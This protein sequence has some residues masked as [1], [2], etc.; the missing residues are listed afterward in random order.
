MVK[1][2]VTFLMFKNLWSHL[3]KKRQ[4]QFFL[5]LVLMLISSISEVISMGAILPFLGV[6]TS[7]EQIYNHHL[8]QPIIQMLEIKGPEQLLLPVT[9]IFI[10]AAL[11]AGVVRIVLLYVMT[12]FSYAAGADI[13]IDIYRRTL[14][15]KYSDHIER[16][17]SEVINSIIV[18]TNTV[19]GN[20]LNPAL[21]MISSTVLLIGILYVL[22]IV[23]FKMTI[24]AISV[25]LT[26][27][28]GISFYTRKKLSRNSQCISDQSTK[29]IRSLQE[30]LGGIRDV[31]INGSQPFYCKLYRDADLALRSATGDN[32]FISQSP[33]YLME[34]L[35]MILIALLAYSMTQDNSKEVIPI[36]G[37][38]ALG[39]QKLLPVL[40][41]FYSSYSSI[42]GASSSFKD[43]LNLL[44]QPLPGYA[45]TNKLPEPLLHFKKEIKLSDISFR[46]A[47]DSPWVV[48]DVNLTIKK[49]E[50]VGFVG[51]TGDGKS[52]LVDIIMGLLFPEKG[53][54]KVDGKIINHQNIRSWHTCIAH[55]PQN[56]F[57]SD[58]TIEENI[59]FG[60]MKEE[61]DQSLLKKVA[62]QAKV[63]DF[64][65]K[66]HNGYQTI[67]GEQGVKLSGGQRQR[68]GIA[69]ALYN[70]SKVLVLDEATSALDSKTECEVMESIEEIDAEVT[71]LIIAHRITTLKACDKVVRLN[72]GKVVSVE[73]YQEL[74]NNKGKPKV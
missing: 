9:L 73:S 11:F 8:L 18:K 48:K 31:I 54:V 2:K 39:A 55:V 49:G 42:N 22:F 46:Y 52:T 60:K 20:I 10:G 16:N 71:I 15:Q 74:I 62:K 14:Y 17:S 43:V 68:I 38:L 61:I 44:N 29:M 34:T 41:Q 53:V 21:I 28:L 6:I 37:A 57:L 36:L 51:T 66:L 27:Y 30:G 35:G 32:R 3:P 69:R 58:G 64:V 65:E 72:K 1:N 59:A 70:K 26:L 50:C 40:Q 24:I 45:Y 33:R 4:R 5:I 19:I 23:N 47:I 13:S 63:S 56:I 25:F 12:K 67:I 7:P